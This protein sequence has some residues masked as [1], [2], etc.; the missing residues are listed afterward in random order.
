MG[1]VRMGILDGFYGK[2]GT[3]VGSFWKGKPVMRAYV[4]PKGTHTSSE[5]QALVQTRFGAI[6]SLSGAFLSALQLGFG[7]IA[8]Q[9]HVTEGNVFV[10]ENWDCIH[11]DTPGAATVDY[12]ELVIARGHLPEVLFGNAS[13]AEPL[14]V[15]VP[16]TDT[17]DVIGADAHDKVYL[18]VYS[19]EAGAGVMSDGRNT[20]ADESLSVNVPAYWNGHRVHVWGFAIGNGPDNKGVISDSRYLGSGT[21][22]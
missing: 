18:F 16:M 11:A 14:Q 22:S 19:P 5:A 1:K 15:A 20:R 9:R 8:R 7:P 2:V 13:F 10:T 17:S 6:N 12:T 3:V 4:R 21:I